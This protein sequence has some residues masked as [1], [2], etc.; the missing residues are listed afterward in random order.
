MSNV[1][2]GIV[3]NGSVH[4]GAPMPLLDGSLVDVVPIAKPHETTSAMLETLQKQPPIPL[5]WVDELEAL[6]AEGDRAGIAFN[7]LNQLSADSEAP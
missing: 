5:E 1:Y 4:F 6:I 3:H 2:R 7:P